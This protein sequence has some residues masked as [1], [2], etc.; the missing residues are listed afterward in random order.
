[1]RLLVRPQSFLQRPPG[2]HQL[3]DPPARR[4]RWDCHGTMR[5]WETRG[6]NFPRNLELYCQVV[7]HLRSSVPNLVLCQEWQPCGILSLASHT[8]VLL[9]DVEQESVSWVL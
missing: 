1:Q 8:G 9:P 6:R 4:R 3:G 7:T 2:G 5:V